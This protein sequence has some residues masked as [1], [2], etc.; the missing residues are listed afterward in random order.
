MA[1]VLAKL[2]RARFHA[3]E[4]D[5]KWDWYYHSGA[6]RYN[7]R[8]DEQPPHVLRF[9]WDLPD[10]TAEQ[11]RPVSDLSFISGAMLSNLLATLPYLF[12]QLSRPATTP[13]THPTAFP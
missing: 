8:M 5:A 9:W 2:D 7:M 11:A 13:P 6:Y 10:R 3:H 12:T 1:M 4:F